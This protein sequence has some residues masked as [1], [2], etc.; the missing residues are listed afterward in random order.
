VEV[1]EF[2]PGGHFSLVG[3]FNPFLAV[4]PGTRT[5]EISTYFGSTDGLHK[6]CSIAH[7]FYHVHGDF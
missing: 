3:G 1:V 2:R 6:T 5:E 7:L 4:P